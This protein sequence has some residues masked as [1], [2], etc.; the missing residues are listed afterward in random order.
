MK[1]A[2]TI[3]GLMV[4]LALVGGAAQAGA[5]TEA[6]HDKVA[7]AFNAGS[8]DVSVYD[9]KARY[10]GDQLVGGPKTFGDGTVLDYRFVETP[11]NTAAFDNLVNGTGTAVKGRLAGK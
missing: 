5:L 1:S 8:L 7:N 3:L 2:R 9:G 11:T 6:D 4:V 10:D